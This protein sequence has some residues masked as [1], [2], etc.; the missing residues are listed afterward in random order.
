[1]THFPPEVIC[2]APESQRTHSLTAPK[3]PP[4]RYPKPQ[5]PPKPPPPPTPKPPNPKPQ[6]SQGGAQ[7]P[8]DPRPPKACFF[9]FFLWGGGGFW[10][11]R[12]LG[13]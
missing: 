1:M 11:F 5:N 4:D 8:G 2:E 9:F 10:G 12:A 6:T 3:I 13:F 7:T